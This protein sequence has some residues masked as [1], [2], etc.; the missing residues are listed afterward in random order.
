[1]LYRVTHGVQEVLRSII[2]KIDEH[3]QTARAQTYAQ[4]QKLQQQRNQRAIDAARIQ[5]RQTILSS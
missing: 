5:G 1:M 2:D 3:A 4:Q